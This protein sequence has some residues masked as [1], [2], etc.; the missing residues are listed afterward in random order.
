MLT[1]IKHYKISH[2]NLRNKL[3]KKILKIYIMNLHKIKQA[4]PEKVGINNKK[5]ILTKNKMI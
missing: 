4:E 1:R 3:F 5:K 2:L